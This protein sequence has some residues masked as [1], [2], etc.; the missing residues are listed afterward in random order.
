MLKSDEGKAMIEKVRKLSE[1]AKR[2]DT[3]NTILAL[4]WCV[5]NPRCTNV[6]L[7]ATKPEQV[8]RLY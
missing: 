5:A 6:I 3:S 8:C 7:G 2:L 1:V 4:A